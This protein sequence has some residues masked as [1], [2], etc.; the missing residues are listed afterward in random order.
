MGAP[1]VAAH[2]AQELYNF[3]L[4]LWQAFDLAFAYLAATGLIYPDDLIMSSPLYQ[5]F[6]TTPSRSAWP[7]RPEPQPADTYHLDP[8]SPI[9][10][11]AA[12]VPPFPSSAPPSALLAAWLTGDKQ[13]TV[14]PIAQRLLLQILRHESD[15]ENYDLDADRGFLHPCWEC[16]PGTSIAAPVLSVKVLPYAAD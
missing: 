12:T 15:S 8:T 11:P 10:Q 4:L 5:Q 14:L 13:H 6:V 7:H 16:A 1:D 2:I 9:E 3:H